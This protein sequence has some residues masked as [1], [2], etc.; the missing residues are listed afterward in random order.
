MFRDHGTRVIKDLI[1]R[2]ILAGFEEA[3]IAVAS[4]TY[5]IVGLPPIEVRDARE[6]TQPDRPGP[7]Q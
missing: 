5:T 1:A 2:D 3:G 4:A 6:A 7:E